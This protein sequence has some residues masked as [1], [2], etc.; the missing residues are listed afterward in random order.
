MLSLLFDSGMREIDAV[1]GGVNHFPLAMALSVG[2]DDGFARLRALLD[3]PEGAAAT[4]IWMD[5]PERTGLGGG[6]ATSGRKADVIAN[7]AVRV[8]LFKRFG[9]LTCSGDHHAAEFVPGF[10]HADNDYGKAWR[11]HIYGCAKHMADADDDVTKYE[12]IRDA[13][14]VPAAA[15]LANSSRR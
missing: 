12:S 2:G 15:R 1:L 10:V 3:D 5:P 11:V 7:N 13:D 6:P 14:D 8:E 4:P 9:V